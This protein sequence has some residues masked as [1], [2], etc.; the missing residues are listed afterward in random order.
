MTPPVSSN[1]SCSD[2][3]VQS[4]HRGLQTQSASPTTL[5]PTL[6]RISCMP[7]THHQQINQSV[8]DYQHLDGCVR[9]RS[10][11]HHTQPA[12]LSASVRHT[13][14]LLRHNQQVNQTHLWGTHLGASQ[15]HAQH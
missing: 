2:T 12:W 3:Q 1:C 8:T 10:C 15:L 9:R 13:W 11:L 4:V 7:S 14:Q 5:N 6:E